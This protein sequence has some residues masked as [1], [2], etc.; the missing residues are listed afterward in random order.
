MKVRILKLEE[1]RDQIA[2]IKNRSSG[3]ILDVENSVKAIIDNVKNNGNRALI[4]LTEKFDD[5]LLCEKKIIVKQNEIKQA[6]SKLSFSEILAIKNAAKNI[7]NYA[8]FQ[9]PKQWFKETSTGIKI[10][11]IIKPIEKIGCYIPG[12]RYPLPSTVLMSVIPAKVAGVKEIVIATPP[13]K[14]GKINPAILVA[15]DVAGVT[16]IIKVGG[17]QAVAAMAYGTKSIPKVDKIVGPGNIYVTA[18]K[19]L[20]YG[21]VGIDML[22]GPSEVLIIADEDSNP[23]FIAADMLAQAEHDPLACSILVTNSIEL[24]NATKSE[25]EKQTEKLSSKEIIKQS[26]EKFSCIILVNSLDEAIKFS[27]QFAPEHLELMGFEKEIL[28]E[29]D[30]AGSVFL[31]EYS[32]EAAGDYCSGT[33]HIL[34]TGMFSKIR[35]GL[36]VFDF[37]KFITVQNLSKSGLKKL[38]STISVL[39]DMENL[40]A[41]KNSSNIRFEVGDSLW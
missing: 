39:A 11:V 34:P 23:K 22:A 4:E 12:G 7:K 24:A 32:V 38:N 16:K 14:N 29:I 19:K 27:N 28:K 40:P 17:A 25:I 33:N 35:G 2:R 8:R 6:Y 10:G 20:L 18:A 21:I 9:K 5:V 13:Q 36:S 15:A 41:H 1:E 37:L 3:N 31:G 30:N 26:F